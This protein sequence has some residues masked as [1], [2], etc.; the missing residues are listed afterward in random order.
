[1]PL[2]PTADYY[3]DGAISSREAHT[4]RETDNFD[5]DYILRQ[6]DDYYITS[7]QASGMDGDKPKK[8]LIL[9]DCTAHFWGSYKAFMV[10]RR[11]IELMDAGFRIYLGDN[12]YTLLSSE[13]IDRELVVYQKTVFLK[14]DDDV[15]TGASKK[16]SK[17]SRH[18][19]CLDY[20]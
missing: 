18:F 16:L 11:L 20:F 13:T 12:T 2:T 4:T 7:G 6:R 3:E 8:H 5:L 14:H 15:R 19:F 10:K 9:N 17:A 1:M